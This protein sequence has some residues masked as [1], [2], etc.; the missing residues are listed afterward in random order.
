MMQALKN[1]KKC[2][3]ISKNLRVLNAVYVNGTNTSRVSVYRLP[4]LIT[5]DNFV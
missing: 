3:N 1:I 5:T 4:P 2:T